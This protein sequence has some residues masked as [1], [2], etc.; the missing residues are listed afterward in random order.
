MRYSVWIYLLLYDVFVSLRP[1]GTFIHT[2]ANYIYTQICTPEIERTI[3]LN[4]FHQMEMCLQKRINRHDVLLHTR[5]KKC[6][7]LCNRSINTF[8]QAMFAS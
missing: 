5:E 4:E 7:R 2:E 8:I 6:I 1:I 3:F